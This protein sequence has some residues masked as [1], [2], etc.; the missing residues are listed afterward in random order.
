MLP[1][2]NLWV[3]YKKLKLTQQKHAFTNQKKCTTKLTPGLVAFY[4]IRRGNGVG[5]FSNEKICKGEISNEK[6]KKK[7]QVEKHTI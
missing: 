7:G 1:Q 4:D 6:E 5:L 2:A 3:W